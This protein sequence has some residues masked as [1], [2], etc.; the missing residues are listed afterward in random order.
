[1]LEFR[2]EGKPKTWAIT[3][4]RRPVYADG[5]IPFRCICVAFDPWLV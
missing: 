2:S 3:I 1:M 4:I 5:R